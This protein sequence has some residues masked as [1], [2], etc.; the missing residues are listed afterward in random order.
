MLGWVQLLHTM[1]PLKLKNF[2]SVEFLRHIF[3]F[4]ALNNE[5]WNGNIYKNDETFDPTENFMT[6][7]TKEKS[8]DASLQ[9]AACIFTVY[10]NILA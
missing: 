6:T 4:R 2:E 8:D 3:E 10:T 9:P 5:T 7:T 1:C